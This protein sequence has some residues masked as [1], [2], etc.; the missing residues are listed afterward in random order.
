MRQPWQ[1]AESSNLTE[2][3]GFFGNPQFQWIALIIA[4]STIVFWL[5]ALAIRTLLSEYIKRFWFQRVDRRDVRAAKAML[6]QAVADI[7]LEQAE[8]NAL[9]TSTSELIEANDHLLNE[10]LR[11]RAML[12][13][14]RDRERI[15]A[16]RDADP[17]QI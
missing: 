6:E 4:V 16:I 8:L 10:N 1:S 11:L 5:V 14:K 7:E 13:E 15:A 9:R 17:H 12:N 3:V 2:I